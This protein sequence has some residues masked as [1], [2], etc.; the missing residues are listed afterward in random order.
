MD[1]TTATCRSVT[2]NN[3]IDTA[4]ENNTGKALWIYNTSGTPTQLT[5]V[6]WTSAGGFV[7]P[8]TIAGT[9]GNV[10]GVQ[11]YSDLNTTSIL[12][13]FHDA[14]GDLFYRA[15][16]GS[17]WE[18]IGS[19]LHTDLCA[20]AD[21]D[22][23]PYGF[24]FDRNLESLVAYRWF[25]NANSTDVGAALTGQDTPYT[26][27]TA[28]QAFR[29]RLLIYYP[30]SLA[31]SGRT[32]NLQFVDP[33][34]GT[35]AAPTGGTPATWTDVPT[36]GSQISFNN[37]AS[38]ADGDN[39]TANANDPT[40]T[41]TIR[42]QDYEESNTFTNS[43]IAMAGSEVGK[44]DFSLIDNTTYDRSAQTFCFRVTRSNGLVLSPDIYPQITT[45]S[46]LDVLILGGTD[47]IQGTL[48][49]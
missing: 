27:S 17:A 23:E 14:N 4:F 41:G 31:I 12:S 40:Y 5:Y 37:N 3:L 45:A 21:D 2:V 36:S 10:E 34:T 13:V 18:T 1:G 20:A 22:T 26:L 30:D 32:Y 9:T 48:I 11:L 42:D 15:W 38:P 33:G 16:D 39:L 44:W 35:C 6:T 49:Q 29:L 24:G 47:I 46:V 43:V 7:A 8:S 19:A 28:N 25:A